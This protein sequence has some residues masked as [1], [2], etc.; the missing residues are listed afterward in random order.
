MSELRIPLP[1]EMEP[2]R[3]DLE[4]F[5][6][7]MVRKLHENSHKGKWENIGIGDAMRLLDGEL[8]E[9]M[10]ALSS[11]EE[12]NIWE[13]AADVSNFCLIISSM[14][15]SGRSNPFAS[16]V[17]RGRAW[18]FLNWAA[19]Q[20]VDYCL[21]WPYR[22]RCGPNQEYGQINKGLSSHGR[23]A[24]RVVCAL[25]HGDPPTPDHHAE[26]LCGNSLCVN[27]KHLK[28]STPLENQNRK[29]EHGTVERDHQ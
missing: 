6:A 12:T 19:K 26:H 23:R 25:A 2:Y 3:H 17:Q 21:L 27:P 10:D 29:K 13:E 28:W 5:V 24:H 22:S 7:T 15:Y 9:L 1:A 14:V 11:G 4:Y 8:N 20:D 16:S 18:D